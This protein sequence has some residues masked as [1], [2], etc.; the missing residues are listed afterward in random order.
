MTGA[1][2]DAR[3]PGLVAD[4]RRNAATIAGRV[5]DWLFGDYRASRGLAVMRVGLGVCI[6]GTLASTFADRHYVWGRGARWLAPLVLDDGYGFPFTFFGLGDTATVFTVKYLLLAVAAVA[7]IA[8]WRTRLVAPLVVIGWTSLIRL[9]PMAF[10]AGDRIIQIVGL[11]A[12]F[13][14]TSR[15]CSLDARR[16]RRHDAPGLIERRVPTWLPVLVSNAAVLAIA[17]Q[18]FVIYLVSSMTK[19]R[20]E[21]WQDGTAIYYPLHLERYEVWP[22]VNEQLT[23]FGWSVTVVSYIAVFSQLFFPFMLLRKGTRTVAILLVTGMHVGIAVTMGLPWFS[24]AMVSADMVLVSERTWQALGRRAR[25]ALARFRR[26]VGD[27]GAI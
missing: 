13:A 20:G 27:L 15:H 16:R 10:D 7:L 25:A 21:L 12:C 24:L 3:S 11:Y 19:I 17:A 22:W 6:L 4:A 8:G 18:V 23:R 2:T 14:D 5:Q 9:D 1:P 26:P